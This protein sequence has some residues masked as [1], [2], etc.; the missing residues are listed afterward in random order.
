MSD[1]VIT[2]NH[3]ET[4]DL[5]NLILIVAIFEVMVGTAKFEVAKL[6]S[7]AD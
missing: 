3:L 7:H 5:Q 2:S 4:Y 6:A 1:F